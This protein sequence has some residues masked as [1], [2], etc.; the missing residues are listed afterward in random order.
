MSAPPP[1]SMT[2]EEYLTLEETSSVRYEYL[3]GQIYALAGGNAVYAII[4]SNINAALHG[5]LRRRP[6]VVYTSDMKIKIERTRLYTY[7]DVAVVCGP[8]R[9]EDPAQRVLLNPTVIVEVLSESTEK[10]DRGKKFQHYRTIESLQE[11]ILVAQ[12]A[13]QVEH[14]TRQPD[15]LW[16]L[17]SAGAEDEA[18]KL[19]SIDC[20]LRMDEIYEKVS[21]AAESDR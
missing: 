19:P 11:Y 12:D 8:A 3:A 15:N 4:C 17:A 14:Y 5:Q 6:C 21:F 9:F 1:I 10:Y 18:V 7:P 16:L 2:V 13:R 20:V